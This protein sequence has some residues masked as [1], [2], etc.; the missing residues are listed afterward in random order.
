M[1]TG[2]PAFPRNILDH[3]HNVTTIHESGMSLRDYFAAHASEED[4][5]YWQ[6]M[7]VMV[8]QVRE[9]RNGS[10]Q[11]YEAPGM[12]TREQ[13]RYRYADAMLAAREQK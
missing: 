3:G 6:P 5:K 12:Y 11:L 1:N 10:K 13:A 7:G 2:G 9:L 4:I 8:T